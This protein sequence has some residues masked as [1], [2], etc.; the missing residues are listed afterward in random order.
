VSRQYVEMTRL[1]V[2][3][4]LAAFPKLIG[5]A[6][7][8]N[9]T[10]VETDTVRY[11]Y[12]PLENQLYLLLVTTKASNIVEDLST[13]RLLA[14]VIPDVAGSIYED[15]INDHAFELIFAFDEVIAAGG[16]REDVSL[17]IIRTNLLM[18]SHEEKMANMIQESKE[19]AAKDNMKK[20]AKVIKDRQMQNLKQSLFDGSLAQNKMAGMGMGG[21]GGTGMDGFGSGGG[22]GFGGS[23]GFDQS[24]FG[25]QGG[26]NGAGN[27]YGQPQQEVKEPLR[28]AAKG[29]KL[30]GGGGKKKDSL[31]AAMAAEDNLLPLSSKK[32]GSAGGLSNDLMGGLGKVTA[33]PAAPSAPVSLV[34][35]EKVNVQMNREGGVESC[36]IKGTLT[37]TANTEQGTLVTVGVNKAALASLA[38]GWTF[39]THPKV[40]KPQYEK[41]GKLGLKDAKRGFPLNRPVGVLR[42][43]NASTDSAPIT[44]NCWPEDMGDGTMNVNIEYELVR[45]DITLTNLNIL[46]PLGTTDPPAIE[47][48]DGAFKHDP[49]AGMMCWHLD[50]VS[51]SNATGSLEFSIAGGD[52]DMFFPVQMSFSSDNLLCPIEVTGVNSTANGSSVP[53]VCTQI[54]TPESYQC[55]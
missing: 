7:Q 22:A 41:E 16:Y 5:H 36:D 9:H 12:Q 3:G 47:S 8:Q 6:Q 18:D 42:W 26:F 28:P 33:A 38:T 13:L 21:G 35:E 34:I 25:Q 49:R 46:I 19:A 14:K 29:M 15:A 20:Q 40:A 43:S 51:G 37:L 10:F 48:I 4:L 24:Q 53:N 54:V 52:P 50:E 45:S 2:E 39:A 30:G 55:A 32:G 27:G 1:R 44:V 11:V 17:S 23:S 31:M